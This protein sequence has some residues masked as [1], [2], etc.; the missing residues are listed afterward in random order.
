MVNQPQNNVYGMSDEQARYFITQALLNASGAG[1]NQQQQQVANPQQ[2][3]QSQMQTNF[4][5][6]EKTPS[7]GNWMKNP[8][9]ISG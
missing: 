2:G 3:D 7:G 5:P 9:L 8:S 1:S 4:S 6:P